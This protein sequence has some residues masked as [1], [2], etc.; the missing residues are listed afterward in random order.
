[1]DASHGVLAAAGLLVGL[2][3]SASP[4]PSPVAKDCHCHCSCPPDPNSNTSVSTCGI[5]ALLVILL[6]TNLALVLRVT[7]RH[8]AS[9]DQE[10]VLS[11]K[12]KPGKGVYGA[13]KG[14]QITDH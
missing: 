7:I 5:V 11:V 6:G 2:W 12:G 4:S 10:W 14:L 9:G 3:F 13:A 1:M 8:S